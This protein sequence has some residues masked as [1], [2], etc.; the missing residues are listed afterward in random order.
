MEPKPPLLRRAKRARSVPRNPTMHALARK[1]MEEPKPLLFNQPSPQ[2]LVAS[3][4]QSFDD[5]GGSFISGR[6]VVERNR[7]RAKRR[8]ALLLPRRHL[9]THQGRSLPAVLVEPEHRPGTFDE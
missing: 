5:W 2:H 7:N 3:R 6:V 8:Q 1:K 9:R 4:L